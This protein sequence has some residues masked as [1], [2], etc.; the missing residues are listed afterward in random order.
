MKT[1]GQERAPE[2]AAAAQVPKGAASAVRPGMA[3]TAQHKGAAVQTRQ[4]AR[5]APQRVKQVPVMAAH[6]GQKSVVAA[7][8]DAQKG[9]GGKSAKRKATS[10]RKSKGKKHGR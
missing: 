7:A 3:G 8:S 6:A 5:E 4:S 1:A 2:S 9:K 10:K